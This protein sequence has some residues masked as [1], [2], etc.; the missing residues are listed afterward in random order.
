[1]KKMAAKMTSKIWLS[2]SLD[3]MGGYHHVQY[4]K[5]L[6]IQSRENLVTDRQ[7]DRRTR[8]VSQDAAQLTNNKN[9]NTEF[10]ERDLELPP[11]VD[12][13]DLKL[14]LLISVIPL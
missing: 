2:Q 3:I 7:T 11:V 1:M 5:K 9:K 14:L 13:K 10:E 8:V 6:T 4:Q 12:L